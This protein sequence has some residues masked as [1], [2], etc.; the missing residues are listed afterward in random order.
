MPAAVAVA[1]GGI[2][3]GCDEAI[4]DRVALHSRLPN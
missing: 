2:L 4:F 3:G 1:H